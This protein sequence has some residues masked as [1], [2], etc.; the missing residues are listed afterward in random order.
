ML[1]VGE[2]AEGESMGELLSEIV[3]E[4]G[5]FGSCSDLDLSRWSNERAKALFARL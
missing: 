4:G 1:A 3:A 5:E 2:S